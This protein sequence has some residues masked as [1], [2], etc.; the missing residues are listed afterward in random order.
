ML[1]SALKGIAT[2]VPGL[3]RSTRGSTGGSVSAR[4]CYAVW[5]RHLSMVQRASL[6]VRFEVVAELGP[7]D[8]LGLGLAA[9]LTG[10]RTYYA[11][12]IVPYTRNDR[13]LRVLRDLVE[14]FRR[15][16]PVPDSQEFPEVLPRL[17]DWSFPG[18][19]L[20]EARLDQTLH[21]ARVAAIE[22][23]LLNIEEGRG[24]PIEIRYHAPWNAAESIRESSVDLIFSQAVLE[25]I[26]DLEGTYAAMHRWLRPQGVLS[27]QIDLRAH[28]LDRRWNGHWTYSDFV[29]SL[30]RG[31]R[32]YLLNRQP[33][34]THLSLLD[35][36]GFEVIRAL[37]EHLASAVRREQLAPRFR[38]LSDE[39]MTTS[40]VYIQA[41]R[42]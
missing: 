8:S 1:V 41:R 33:L 28:Y 10:A 36:T 15:R 14:L 16:E 34:S 3:Y 32:P 18:R 25:H 2:Y 12:D 13:N 31:R 39:D 40:S 37:K 6:P 22:R 23:A 17:Q 24:G 11:F 27:Q 21:P 19:V 5:M 30:I 7:G 42:R 35:R 9:L 38:H 20:T 29:W 4:Y 26:D